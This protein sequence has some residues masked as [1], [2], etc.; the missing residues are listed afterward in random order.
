LRTLT[1]QGQ[2]HAPMLKDSESIE[3]ITTFLAA[4]D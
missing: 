1:V 3:A 4:N 2:G